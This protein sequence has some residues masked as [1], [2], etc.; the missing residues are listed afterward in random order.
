MIFVLMK[1]NEPIIGLDI[2]TDGQINAVS[3]KI[4]N[5]ELLPIAY[6][7]MEHGLELWWK[8]RSVP[9]SRDYIHDML[10]KNDVSCPE[11]YLTRTVRTAHCREILK[12]AGISLM[13]NEY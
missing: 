5:P 12:R 9:A 11:E 6:K 8:E 3:K 7:N 2:S 4:T 1:K 13:E 10:Q